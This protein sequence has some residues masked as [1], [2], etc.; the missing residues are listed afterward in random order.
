[1]DYSRPL[2]TQTIDGAEV[3]H[4]DMI[5]GYINEDGLVSRF[6]VY[7]AQVPVPASEETSEE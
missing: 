6:Y 2:V 1:M 5:D 3:R 4:R 7:T